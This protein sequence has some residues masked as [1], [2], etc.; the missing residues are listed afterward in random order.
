MGGT[1]KQGERRFARVARRAHFR[2]PGIPVPANFWMV[3]H[4][5]GGIPATPRRALL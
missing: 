3:C 4:E 5:A 1:I 2:T